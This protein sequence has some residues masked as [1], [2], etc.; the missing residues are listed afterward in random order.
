MSPRV[1]LLRFCCVVVAVSSMACQFG[2]GR[3]EVAGS[4][5]SDAVRVARADQLF[6]IQTGD[7]RAEKPVLTLPVGG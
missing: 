2:P 3:L 1:R 5:Y 7:V 4:H 6:T